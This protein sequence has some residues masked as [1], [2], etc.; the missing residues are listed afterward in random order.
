MSNAP[1]LPTA[2]GKPRAAAS[3]RVPPMAAPFVSERARKAL[4]I[5]EKFVEEECI[6][7]DTVAAA[8]VSTNSRFTNTT[9]RHRWV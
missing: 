7:A 6:P 9:N 1:P 3:Q 2:G 4:D 8:Q 5:V